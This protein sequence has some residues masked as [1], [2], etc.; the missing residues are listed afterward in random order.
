[1]Q[2]FCTAAVSASALSATAGAPEEMEGALPTQYDV[3]HNQAASRFEINLTGADGKPQLAVAEYQICGVGEQPGGAASA[4]AA[5]A[6]SA[7]AGGLQVL[8]LYHTEVPPADRGK[9]IADQLL[10]GVFR[11]AQ[12]VGVAVRP[13]C[14]YVSET[15]LPR[16]PEYNAMCEAELVAPACVERTMPSAAETAAAMEDSDDDEDD[17]EWGERA[18]LNM[19]DHTFRLARNQYQ[20]QIAELGFS[21]AEEQSGARTKTLVRLGQLL[22][23]RVLELLPRNADPNVNAEIKQHVR[24]AQACAAQLAEGEGEGGG[25]GAAAAADDT[26]AEQKKFLSTLAEAEKLL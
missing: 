22:L 16:H 3:T 19:Q 9:G 24:D 2:F 26:S 5:A 23:N 21:S 20:A 15:W 13:S 17:E 4:A 8:D 10:A 12:E 6:S 18:L 14:S 1:M 25:G 7:A 11:H